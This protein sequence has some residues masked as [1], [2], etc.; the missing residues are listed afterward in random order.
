MFNLFKTNK[1]K[2]KMPHFS[3]RVGAFHEKPRLEYLLP[4]AY[5]SA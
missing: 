2:E 5:V 1:T 4:W 3:Q